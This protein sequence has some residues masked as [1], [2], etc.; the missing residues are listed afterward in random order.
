[1]KIDNC[2]SCKGRIIWCVTEAGN[3]QPID[4]DPVANGNIAL[5]IIGGVPHSKVVRPED[6]EEDVVPPERYISHHATCPQGKAWK[7]RRKQQTGGGH[8]PAA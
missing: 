4:A 7:A 8:E 1:M 3:R 2:R 6:P 5:V